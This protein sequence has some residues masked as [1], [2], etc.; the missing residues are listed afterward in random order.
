MHVGKGAWWDEFDGVWNA[1]LAT[2]GGEISVGER[3]EDF[4]LLGIKNPVIGAS[5]VHLFPCVL[6]IISEGLAG[7]L[8]LREN[9]AAIGSTGGDD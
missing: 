5:G 6:G 1:E 9:V 7:I 4:R 8:S 3:P 2:L